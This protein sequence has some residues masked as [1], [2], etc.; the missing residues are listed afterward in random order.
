VTVTVLNKL[1]E[2]KFQLKMSKI[3][4]FLI[5]FT[6]ASKILSSPYKDCNQVPM[7]ITKIAGGSEADPGQFP[8][9]AA[10][11]H[12]NIFHCGGTLINR[13]FIITGEPSGCAK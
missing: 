13:N 3:F 8:W 5:I 2:E 6:I 1:F 10:I 9:A 12:K 4:Q 7:I 11:F